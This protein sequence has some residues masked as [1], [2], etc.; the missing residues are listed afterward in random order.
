MLLR[1]ITSPDSLTPERSRRI[2]ED[3]ADSLNTRG[4][5]GVWLSTSGYGFQM[6]GIPDP[7]TCPDC[8]I[9]LRD[10]E[11]GLECPLCGRVEPYPDIKR[12][13]GADDLPGLHGG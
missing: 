3:Y 1:G 8:G 2:G 4:K 5:C 6:D 7:L 12:P 11:T 9:V 13:A 10:G